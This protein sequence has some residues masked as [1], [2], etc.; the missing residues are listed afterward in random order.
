[1]QLCGVKM[2]K[3]LKISAYLISSMEDLAGK[4]LSITT[5]LGMPGLLIFRR[6]R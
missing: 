1:M 4:Q 2:E 6:N 3:R 5:F